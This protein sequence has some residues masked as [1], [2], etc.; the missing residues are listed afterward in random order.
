MR[1]KFIYVHEGDEIFVKCVKYKEGEEDIY[2]TYRI[3][4]TKE[5]VKGEGLDVFLQ[6]TT[7]FIID[8]EEEE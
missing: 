8:E 7:G 4:I 2:S 3:D 6:E 5:T 1:K